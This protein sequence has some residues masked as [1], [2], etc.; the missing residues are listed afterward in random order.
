MMLVRASRSSNV[1]LKA[2]QA[3]KS[4]VALRLP[5]TAGSIDGTSQRVRP[6]SRCGHRAWTSTDRQRL[7]N[8]DPREI[9]HRVPC[10]SISG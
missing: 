1:S 3:A 7:L 4:C 9:Q 6:V 10:S 5:A 8:L 2:I